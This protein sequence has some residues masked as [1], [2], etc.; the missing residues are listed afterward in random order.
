LAEETRQLEAALGA[1]PSGLA[2]RVMSN[3]LYIIDRSDLGHDAAA[4]QFELAEASGNASRIV[5]AC[6]MSSVALSSEGRY[7]EA[8]HLVAR[9]REHAEHTQS[10]TDLASAAVAEGFSSRDDA[11]AFDA[12]VVADRIA[13]SSGNRWMSAFAYTEAS[14]LLVARGEVEEGCAG[15]ADMVDV[16]YRAGD[17]SQQWHTLSRCVIALHHVGKFDLAMEIVGAIEAH[18]TLGVAPMSSILHD[19]AFATR[20]DLVNELGETRAADQREAGARAAVDNIVL[21]T[22]RALIGD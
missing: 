15:L 6:Y 16:W 7:D 21:R 13:R 2:E 9:A 12:F 5:H 10:P 1:A 11:K 3:V 8:G 4:R 14:G 22:R 20:D 17:W 18:A 19:V